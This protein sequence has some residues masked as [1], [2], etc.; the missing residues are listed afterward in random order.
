MGH[1]SQVIRSPV[2]RDCVHKCNTAVRR[3]M[4][5]RQSTFAIVLV[6]HTT[7][8]LCAQ[9]Q[10]APAAVTLG[11]VGVPNASKDDISRMK[12]RLL[13]FSSERVITRV[14]VKLFSSVEL[15]KKPT[16]ECDVTVDEPAVLRE[17]TEGLGNALMFTPSQVEGGVGSQPFGELEVTTSKDKFS[18]FFDAMFVLDERHYQ[19]DNGFMSWTTAKAIENV[20][21]SKAGKR[22]SEIQFKQLSGEM[23]LDAER[24]N[25]QKRNTRK[26]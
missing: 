23:W 5:V 20:L 2:E 1:N 8:H 21:S 25:Y 16:I 15:G 24:I 12:W 26:K 6:V 18:V 7:M 3:A 14:R 13:C 9:E 4:S 19:Y 10:S 22:L 17:F 11:N